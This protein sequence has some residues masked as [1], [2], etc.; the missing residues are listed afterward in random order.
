MNRKFQRS[1]AALFDVVHRAVRA[2]LAVVLAGGAE[3]LVELLQH[4]RQLEVRGRLEGIVIAG[5]GQRHADDDS[6][7]PRAAS[8]TLATSFASGRHSGTP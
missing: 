3:G 5:T 2:D 4:V 1:R 8:L 7:L 6:H